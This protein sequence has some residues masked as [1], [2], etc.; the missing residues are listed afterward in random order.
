VTHGVFGIPTF[1][2]GREIF[3]G[4]DRLTQVEAALGHAA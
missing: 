4:K 1:Q 3:F 2:V